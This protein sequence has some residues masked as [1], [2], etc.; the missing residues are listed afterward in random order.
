MNS[1]IKGSM[2]ALGF[3]YIV[4]SLRLIEGDKL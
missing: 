2:N 4:E 1:K 3:A